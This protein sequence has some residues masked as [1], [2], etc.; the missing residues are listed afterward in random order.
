[1]FIPPYRKD[2]L[3][4]AKKKLKRKIEEYQHIAKSN[5]PI[6]YSDIPEK[7]HDESARKLYDLKK[8]GKYEEI[9]RIALEYFK[10]GD[11]KNG[12]K[13]LA[14]LYTNSPEHFYAASKKLQQCGIHYS[15]FEGKEPLIRV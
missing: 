14:T 1:M 10:N 6:D 15:V 7:K 11:E 9:A 12:E 3:D 2:E 5:L 4:F 13:Y 8:A